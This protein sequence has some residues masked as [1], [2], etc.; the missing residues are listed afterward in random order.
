[1]P[2]RK[3]S[4]QKGCG[5][6]ETRYDFDLFYKGIRYRERIVCKTAQVDRVYRDWEREQ[7][8]NA[9]D[10]PQG[11]Y[12]F[13]EYL[14]VYL[15]RT[16]SLKSEKQREMEQ[17]PFKKRILE[18]FPNL[19]LEDV[20]KVHIEDYL[21]WRRTNTYYGRP[22]SKST[23]NKDL[24]VLSNMFTKAI[25][26]EWYSRVN[27][28][29]GIIIHED[30]E[31]HI[32]IPRDGVSEIIE[33]VSIDS[34]LKVA[35]ALALYAGLRK[36]EVIGLKWH[37]VNFE[38][39]NIHVSSGNAKNHKARD[40][41]L[42][43]ELKTILTETGRGIGNVSITGLTNEQ[44]R[45]RWERV[46]KSFSF[47]DLLPGEVLRFHDLRHIFAQSCR[48]AEIPMGDIQTWLG[49]S[50]VVTT[51]RRYAQT[52]GKDGVN[53]INKLSSYLNAETTGAITLRST[54]ESQVI[55]NA[56]QRF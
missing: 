40:I 25:E 20:R 42:S 28:C 7:V 35:V 6:S 16:S 51:E 55:V 53:K 54:Y 37:D 17:G 9:K 33:R 1:M 56:C 23:V 27:P 39:S 2:H 50:S 36:N 48:D 4:N 22:V 8:I 30:N 44:L 15:E 18:T 14:E 29:K 24:N 13:H 26:Y 47:K 5:R 45:Y 31:R 11:G 32:N 10:K 3:W 52:G 38:T 43:D 41:P 49:H 46:N 19:P 34:S 12:T 21:A